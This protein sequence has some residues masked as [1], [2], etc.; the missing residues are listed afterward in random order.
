VTIARKKCI[1]LFSILVI[2][3]YKRSQMHWG[4]ISDC[5]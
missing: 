4:T 3:L 1:F 5:F 2:E